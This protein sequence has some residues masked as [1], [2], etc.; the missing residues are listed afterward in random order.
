MAYWI[1]V[2]TFALIFGSLAVSYNI[3]VGY[4][5][6]LSIAH[7]AFFSVGAYVY[8]YFG[9]VVGDGNW[10]IVAVLLAMAI[11]AAISIVVGVVI[12]LLP[13]QFVIMGTFA[14]QVIFT[15]LLINLTSITN[16]V[17]GIAGIP[18]PQIGPLVFDT[19]EASLIMAAALA[20]FTLGLAWI[21][22]KSNIGLRS[23]AVRDD[24][25]AAQ[26]MGISVRTVQVGF[27]AIGAMLA[28]IAGTIYAGVIGYIDPSTFTIE[29][30]VQL[31]S[32]VV[33]GGIG[34]PLGAMLGGIVISVL[35]PLL[36]EFNIGESSAAAIQQV[37]FGVAMI[38][39]IMLRPRGLLPERLIA[40]KRQAS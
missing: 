11:A 1:T 20:V 26:S 9:T 38:A 4:V 18:A 25:L 7:A 35:P 39:V 30:S 17:Q 27:F 14:L 15:T 29:T 16:G 2:I 21:L 19:R 8:G 22:L 34:N 33:I 36:I 40:R 3:S 10:F 23:R 32:M 31:L 6:M 37:L 24:A 13:E 12:T 28:A 5:G